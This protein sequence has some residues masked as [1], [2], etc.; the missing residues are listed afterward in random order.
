LIYSSQLISKREWNSTLAT[1]SFAKPP[2]FRF[3]P[4]Q[5]VLISKDK[6][7][8]D[9]RPFSISSTNIDPVLELSIRNCGEFS[10]AIHAAQLGTPYWIKG[11]FGMFTLEHSEGDVIMIAG[12]IGI[13]PFLSTLREN[14]GG[15]RNLTL[16]YSI[17]TEEDILEREAL[18]K[19]ANF[20]NIKII[21]LFSQTAP[22]D[23]P[24]PLGRVDASF[25]SNNIKE[26]Q[27][28]SFYLCGPPPMVLALR[29]ALESLNVKED[30][31]RVDNWDYAKKVAELKT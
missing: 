18:D 12:G 25:I 16:I 1:F 26:L 13:T 29:Q 3:S 28:K 5:F 4:G 27:S 6:D 31:I 14:A 24:Y 11:P 17:K 8:L 30:N 7:F 15:Q 21:Y 22:E 23:S 10:K 2:T 19:L 9:P 20:Q